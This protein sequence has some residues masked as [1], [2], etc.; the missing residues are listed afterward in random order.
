MCVFFFF[1]FF[2]GGGGG[3]GGGIRCL[4]VR[5]QKIDKGQKKMGMK[6]I[7]NRLSKHLINYRLLNV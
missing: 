1:F 4:C 5:R 3:G 6:T 2:F 7:Y